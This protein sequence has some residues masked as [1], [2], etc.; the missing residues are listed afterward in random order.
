MKGKEGHM[1]V[2]ISMCGDGSAN[3]GQAHEAA[4]MAALWKLPH[5][6]I[7]ENNQY[8]M[9]TSTARS[10]FLTEYYKQGNMIPGIQCDG[11]DVLA[12]RECMRFA[13][14]YCG[15]GNGP[16]FVEFKTYR[17]HGHSMSDPGITYRDR[18]EVNAVRKTS[19]C[20]ELMKSRVIEAGFLTAE[21]VTK[22]EKGVRKTV[23]AELKIAKAGNL[24]S[25]DTI[26]DHIFYEEI[27]AYIRQ[28]EEYPGY[29]NSAAPQHK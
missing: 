8:G 26:N 21:E 16:L 22:M 6:F 11:F 13:K 10:S 9:G 5:I 25:I 28:T 19:D 23:A 12:T 17:Y 4:N 29:F 7:I 3:Q 15:A 27:P 18:D 20:I 1:D 2:S 14:D 24:P